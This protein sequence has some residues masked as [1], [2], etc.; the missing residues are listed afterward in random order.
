[1]GFQTGCYAKVWQVKPSEK[2][3]STNVQLSISRK[4]KS[5]DTYETDFSGFVSFYGTAHQKAELLKEKDR[6]KITSCDVANSYNKDK[7]TTYWY[8][9]VF[10]FEK[11]GGEKTDPKRVEEDAAEDVDNDVPF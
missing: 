11:V 1:M 6:I 3:N 10:D 9:K 2:G 5:T 7:N 8:C 4:N